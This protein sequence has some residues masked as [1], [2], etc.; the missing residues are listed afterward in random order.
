M[1]AR[2]PRANDSAVETNTSQLM[3]R[4]GVWENR[5]PLRRAV[6]KSSHD[7]ERFAEV[8]CETCHGPEPKQRRF[9]MPSDHLPRLDPTG[10]F[11]A[12]E[13]TEPE[14]TAFMIDEVVPTMAEAL[15]LPVYDPETKQ[16]FG[17]FRCHLEK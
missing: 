16:G 9:E 17:C 10:R 11:A 7:A 8:G 12:H 6:E 5:R 2:S 15:G 13:K 1:R 4:S 3:G 14:I